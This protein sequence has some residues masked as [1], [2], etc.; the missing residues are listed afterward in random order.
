MGCEVKSFPDGGFA[1]ICGR[2]TQRCQTPGC[3][4]PSTKLCDWPTKDGNPDGTIKTCDR[5]ICD[6]CA[7][8]INVNIDYCPL[9]A[10]DSVLAL[11]A[12]NKSKPQEMIA[13]SGRVL[14]VNGDKAVKIAT[15][16]RDEWIGFSVIPVE[17]HARIKASAEGDV[18]AFRIPTWL[19]RKMDLVG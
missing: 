4:R 5:R 15:P 16:Y 17:D 12:S 3:G 13:V 1:I 7:T 18:V 10:K 6:A 8:S 11:N 14:H 2:R 19:A 9:H